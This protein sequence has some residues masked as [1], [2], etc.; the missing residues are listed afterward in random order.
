MSTPEKSQ[1]PEHSSESGGHGGTIPLYG[2]LDVWMA[3][4]GTS[5]PDFDVFYAE[6][7]YAETWACILAAVRGRRAELQDAP[8]FEALEATGEEDR[9]IDEAAMRSHIEARLLTEVRASHVYDVLNAATAEANARYK[10]DEDDHE[11][12][13]VSRQVFV[14]GALWQARI[15]AGEGEEK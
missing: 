2:M 13:V 4:Y 14:A 6:H 11:Y 5:H 8:P 15:A 1:A 7:G 3:L 10:Y 9:V 12:E